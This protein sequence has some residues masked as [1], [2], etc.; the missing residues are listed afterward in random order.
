M[1][2]NPNRVVKFAWLDRN[3]QCGQGQGGCLVT[4]TRNDTHV[5]TTSRNK[6]ALWYDF[7]TTIDSTASISK[8]WFEI[9]EGDGSG[10][11]QVNSE[12]GS[13][14]PVE[15]RL[16]ILPSKLCKQT[17]DDGSVNVV[18]TFAVGFLCLN[19]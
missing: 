2:T 7:S 5:T 17:N 15:D 16:F 9:D 6:Q 8:F 19:G 1:Q 18:L 14:F 4:A 3:S 12:N 10:S 13:P 11:K